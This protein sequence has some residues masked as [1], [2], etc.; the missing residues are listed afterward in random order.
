[1]RHFFERFEALPQELFDCYRCLFLAAAG[2]ESDQLNF[3]ADCKFR[4]RVLSPLNGRRANYLRPLSYARRA[5]SAHTRIGR[6]LEREL[7]HALERRSVALVGMQRAVQARPS[8][9]VTIVATTCC[10]ATLS[11]PHDE[12]PDIADE[13]R[14]GGAVPLR[15]NPKQVAQETL[16]IGLRHSNGRRPPSLAQ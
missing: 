9:V 15:P 2:R 12:Q 5:P 16:N 4:L 13:G 1:M 3:F 8:A 14:A 6:R 7:E 10:T 11:M